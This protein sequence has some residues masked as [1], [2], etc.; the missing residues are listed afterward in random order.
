MSFRT[1][2]EVSREAQRTRLAG[3]LQQQ[4]RTVSSPSL[5]TGC[6]AGSFQRG[7]DYESMILMRLRQAQERKR[8]LEQQSAQDDIH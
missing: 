7:D 5:Q 8:Q 1:T 6:D 3:D 4:H 2:E